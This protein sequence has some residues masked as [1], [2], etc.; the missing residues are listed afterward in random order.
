MAAE[1]EKAPKYT[2][3]Q[4]LKSKTYMA[5]YDVFAV[6]LEDGKEYTKEQLEKIK[7]NF[8]NRPVNETVNG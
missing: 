5:Y 3:Q 4:V 8:L 6:A 7:D 2:K 1:K